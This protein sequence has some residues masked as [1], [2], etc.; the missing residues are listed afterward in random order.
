[1]RRL[2]V[3]A[4]LLVLA[5][6][7]A[8]A[9]VAGGTLLAFVAVEGD[10]RLVAVA[11]ADRRIVGR[12]DVADGPH[13]VAATPDGR[14]VLV[15][16]PPAGRVTLLNGRTLRVLKVF[17][18]LGYPHDV[19]LSPDARYAYVTD[20]ARGRLAVLDLRRRRVV[21]SVEVGARPHDL[22]VV[23]DEIW[24]T[25]SRGASRL[26][27]VDVTRP[28]SPRLV[29]RV[30]AGG[31]AHDIVPAPDGSKVFLTYWSSGAVGAIETSSGRP[32]FRRTV[33]EL[34]HHVAVSHAGKVWVTDHHAG[35][36]Y[37]LAAGGGRPLRVLDVGADP[38]HVALVAGH[39]AVTGE[40][41]ELVS[42]LDEPNRPLGKR[43]RSI[44]VGGRAH[45]VALAVVP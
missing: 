29:H 12:I 23:G 4:L 13:N 20:E 14:L 24:V 8:Q 45:G 2:V 6:A 9:R 17:G 28:R 27:V 33:G 38:H 22:A 21:G 5:P 43:W 37:V 3:L 34:V 32:L 30:D 15:T 36:V 25:H 44:G 18:G 11:V 1:M 16:S 10:D 31:P 26:T 42:F 41:G 39:A 35:R 40:S 19:E 7:G